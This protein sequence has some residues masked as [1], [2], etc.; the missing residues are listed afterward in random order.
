MHTHTTARYILLG[1]AAFFLAFSLT[2]DYRRA[3]GY[4]FGDEA[5][6]YMMAQSI[7]YDFDLQY[8]PRDLQRVYA[9]GWHAGP[10]GVFLS[11]LES[12]KIIYAKY[13]A[14]SL[15]LAPFLA[16]FGFNGF[17]VFNVLLWVAMIWM[18]WAYVRQFTTSGRALFIAI[19]FFTL[20]ASFIY[21]FWVTPETFNMACITGGLF[22]WLYQRENAAPR[23]Q[24]TLRSFTDRLHWLVGTPPGRLY[25]APIP[26]AI[27]AASK[28]PNILFLLP[29]LA[30]A[31]LVEP[32]AHAGAPAERSWRFLSLHFTAAD[33]LRRFRKLAAV[34]IVTLLVLGAFYGFQYLMTGQTNAYA[35]DRKTFYGPFPFGDQGEAWEHGIRLSNDDYYE[36]SFFFH[37][38]TF[39]YD[40]YYY[41]F[42]RFTGLLPY[43]ICTFAAVYYAVRQAFRAKSDHAARLRTWRR[44]FLGVAILGSILGYILIAP[45]NYQGGGGAFGNRFFLNIYPAFLF[46]I[47]TLSSLRPMAVTWIIG[48]LFLAHPLLTPFKSSFAPATHAFGFP[49]RFLPIE[50]TLADTLPTNVNPHLMQTALVD[51]APSYRLYFCDTNISDFDE[52]HF[53]VQG[54]QST[55]FLIRTFAGQQ[56]FTATLI[57]GPIPNTVTV[58]TGGH[59]HSISLTTPGEVHKIVF[60]LRDP[61]PFFNNAVYQMKIR[62]ETGFVPTFTP[63]LELR[64]LRYLGVW[65]SVSLS[66]GDA[67]RVYAEQG[68]PDE[69]ISLL[70]PLTKHYTEESADDPAEAATRYALGRAYDEQG[71]IQAALRELNNSLAAFP[72]FQRHFIQEYNQKNPEH[73]IA[74]LAPPTETA[75]LRDILAPITVSY[76]AEALQRQTGDILDDPNASGAQSVEFDAGNDAPGFLAYGQYVTLPAGNY[77]ARLRFQ[78]AAPDDVQAASMPVVA[79]DCDVYSRTYGVLAR[80]RVLLEQRDGYREYTFP[81]SALR[82]TTL[83]IRVRTHDSADILLDSIDIYPALPIKIY[84]QL[85]LVKQAA[86]QRE[87]ARD[88][89]RQVVETD[90]STPEFQRDYLMLLQAS[91]QLEKAAEFAT[92]PE[93]SSRWHTGVATYLEK[94]RT[95]FTPEVAVN[96]TFE[97]K[98]ELVGYDALPQ[99]AITGHPLPVHLY[100]KALQDIPE[101]LHFTLHLAKHGLWPDVPLL[102]KVQQ[103]LGLPYVTRY[104]VEY[105]PVNGAYPTTQWLAEE[106]IRDAHRLDLPANLAPGRYTLYLGV[107]NPAEERLLRSNSNTTL[108]VGDLLIMDQEN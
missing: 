26:I 43:F 23:P 80:R 50:R 55:E 20:S 91:Q 3:A 1:L 2:V 78:S 27:A 66:D 102:E 47:T 70:E 92:A 36:E 34:G 89:L 11:R 83:E 94:P 96:R 63:D 69:A 104:A 4:F 22:L 19:T 98:L 45:T 105:V 82:E 62:S 95:T 51:G 86:G 15:F 107:R 39:V 100:W 71:D 12:G 93:R 56:Y 106:Y 37:P 101:N 90:S 77:Q 29:I 5:V 46:L 103:K 30:D 97:Q 44:G 8:T 10:L 61:I 38:K 75:T 28:V 18:G 65:V 53:W 14:Y 25:L 85:A 31:L 108:K 33:L 42:G 57:N 13:P 52:K 76:E 88:L 24:Y 68:R 17:L 41:V 81:F 6:Y 35:G 64:D 60:P 99:S 54:E 49:Y 67:G 21:T 48:A 58:W 87:A 40:L 32:S 72:T 16:I 79:F 84:H 59:K 74:E 9:D 7:A 73:P